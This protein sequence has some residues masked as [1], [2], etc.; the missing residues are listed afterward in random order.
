MKTAYLDRTC[1]MPITHKGV[2]LVVRFDYTGE[3]EAQHYGD[4][5][6][7]GYPEQVDIGEVFVG[8][9]DI[10][11][12][13]DIDVIHALEAKVLEARESNEEEM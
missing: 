5:P 4:A 13:L 2:D 6:Y 7:P 9:V 3:E 1:E 12:L 10:S 8:G 11:A